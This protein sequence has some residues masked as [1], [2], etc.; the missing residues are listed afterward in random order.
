MFGCQSWFWARYAEP[1]TDGANQSAGGSISNDSVVHSS[2]NVTIP[3]HWAR[4]GSYSRNQRAYDSDSRTV[5][6]VSRSS[7]TCMVSTVSD[8]CTSSRRSLR[9][10]GNML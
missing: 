3:S 1:K 7:Q 10:P 8:S 6:Q 4:M 5:C 9:H 2:R